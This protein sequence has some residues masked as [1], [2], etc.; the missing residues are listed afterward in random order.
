[1]KPNVLFITIDTLRADRVVGTK[2]NSITPNLDNLIKNGVYFTQAISSSDVTGPTL[3]SLFTS[4]FPFKTGITLF[5]DN[6][7]V[8][9][10][11]K[12]INDSGYNVYTLY[13]D[14]SF[15]L[16][17]TANLSENDPYEYSK[18]ES[19]IPLFGGL[20]K[21]IEEK[22]DNKLS[23]PWLY[24]IH[25]M[26]LHAPFHIPPEFNSEKYGPTEHDRMISA[27][28]FWLGKFLEKINLKNTLVVI[29]SDHADYIPLGDN[30]NK[31]IKSNPVLKKG[32]KLFP[33]FEPFFVKILFKIQQSKHE[34]KIKSMKMKLTERELIALDG[35][36][37]KHLF[38]ETINIPLIFSG[39]GVSSPKKITTMVRQ[40]DI[41]PTIADILEIP[42]DKYEIDGKSLFPA[43]SNQKIDEIPA[44]IETGSRHIKNEENASN[45][46]GKVIGIRTSKYKYWRS[47]ND[48][49]K[50]VTLYDLKNDPLEKINIASKN[51]SIVK[52]MEKILKELKKNSFQIEEKKFSDKETKEIEEELKKLGYI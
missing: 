6:Q 28:D 50:D 26:D 30:W 42:F 38:D 13:P 40:V 52:D 22:L 21:R 25:L 48:P 31:P 24:Y 10:F 44:Y 36:A 32:K 1:M 17:I 49:S 16:K 18:R 2:K 35:R 19:W 9:T 45:I 11:F 5:T 51:P 33:M 43:F 29:S 20:G 14:T 8:P 3:G 37:G 41:F 39:Y 34:K 27:I 47:R 4:L 15:F 23:E 46:F 7:K 12:I